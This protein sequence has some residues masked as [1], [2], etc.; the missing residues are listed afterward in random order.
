M[1]KAKPK[2]LADSKLE[3]AKELFMQNM[4]VTDIAKHLNI[5]RTT[6]Q[7]HQNKDG[8][9]EEREQLHMEQFTDYMSTKQSDVTHI[10]KDALM[11]MRRGLSYLAQRTAPPTIDE[12]TKA[13]R[14][15]ETLSK[16]SQ[17]NKKETPSESFES[18]FE[19]QGALQEETI[20]EKKKPK[21]VK[22]KVVDDIKDP[23][24]A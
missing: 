11:V 13:S 16:I 3:D 12:V 2:A 14:A 19:S 7:Y 22:E 8:W 9:K 18:S 1:P 15:M 4:G 20:K 17:G 10:A 5:P 21:K 23:F 24:E 6:L